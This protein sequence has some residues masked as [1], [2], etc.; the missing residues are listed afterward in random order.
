[1]KLG[2]HVGYSG[3]GTVQELYLECRRQEAAAALP[4][5]LIDAVSLCRPPAVV[6]ERLAL[7]RAAGVGTLIVSPMA[8]SFSE[9]REQLRQVA[10]LA[11]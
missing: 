4:D 7:F 2:L 5:E 3:L 1:M 8:W 9:R 10:E 11:A 6:C